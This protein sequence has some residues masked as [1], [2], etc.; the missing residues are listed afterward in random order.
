[1]EVDRKSHAEFFHQ[2]IEDYINNLEKEEAVENFFCQRIFEYLGQILDIPSRDL[3][4]T[5]Q[6]LYH[7]C[8][9]A[10]GKTLPFPA[11]SKNYPEA[12][13]FMQYNSD[14]PRDPYLFFQAKTDNL[15]LKI[16]LYPLRIAAY[17]QTDR[18]NFMIVKPTNENS[19]PLFYLSVKTQ[20]RTLLYGR[21]YDP[22]K[23]EF[24][25]VSP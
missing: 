23:N 20:G 9:Q 1:M 11:E 10:S 3:V 8:L 22:D 17:L 24:I 5:L 25:T 16:Y 12:N 13:I 15:N 21:C 6:N 14:D 18:I 7:S 2:S 19:D 4:K